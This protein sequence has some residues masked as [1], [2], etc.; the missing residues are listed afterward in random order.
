MN[1]A[2][3]K[4]N[5]DASYVSKLVGNKT[6]EI[7]C[8]NS[9]CQ[10]VFSTM[11]AMKRHAKEVNGSTGTTDHEYEADVLKCNIE[12]CKRKHKT[13]GW[14]HKHI[15]ECHGKERV[16]AEESD[17]EKERRREKTKEEEEKNH[18]YPYEGY[19]RRVLPT[20]ERNNKS[21]LQKAQVVGDQKGIR[22]FRERQ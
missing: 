10:I 6:G 18:K 8:E 16:E 4:A 15:K 20:M 12:G 19:K 17:K 9:N 2:L 13:R 7:K 21:L 11:K 22:G 3:E 5:S 1:N 14:L